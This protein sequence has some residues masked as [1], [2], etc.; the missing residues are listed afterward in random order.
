MA[1]AGTPLGMPDRDV[2]RARAAATAIFLLTGTVIAAWSTRVPAIQERLQLS[3]GQLG[4][5]VLGL[6]AG[7]VAGLPAGGA[8]VARAGSPAALRVGFTGFPLGLLAVGLA[9][10]LGALAAAL[11]V[12]AAA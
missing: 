7:A 1:A 8:L 11:A 10:S 6:E 5:A 3:A 2:A 4:L 12:M 9:P